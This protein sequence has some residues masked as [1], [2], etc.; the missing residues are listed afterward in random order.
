MFTLGV[1]NYTEDDVEESARALT[2]W[3]VVDGKYSFRGNRHD[4]GTKK[5]LGAESKLNGDDL[6]GLLLK[7]P[8]TAR[9]IAWRLC[10][11][12]M[13]EGVVGEAGIDELAT[14]LAENK[15][16]IGRA[17]ET[18]LRSQAFFS[19][20]NIQSR[21]LGPVEYVVGAL[22]SLELCDPSPSSLLLAEWVSRMGQDLFYPCLLYTSPSPRD[23]TLSRMPSSA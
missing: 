10:R 2:G 12:F 20:A 7:Q 16:D 5:V 3:A 19:G 8:A 23:A 11:T 9:R 17:V 22:R 18:I 15:L 6:L 1:G 4:E 13:G 14:G 21:V